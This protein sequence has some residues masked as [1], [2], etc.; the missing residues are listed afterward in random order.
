M[1]LSVNSMLNFDKIVT[2]PILTV[3]FPSRIPT[4][5]LRLSHNGIEIEFLLKT[6]LDRLRGPSHHFD[7]TS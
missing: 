7:I 1:A 6:T 3:N 5:N 4:Q 2:I